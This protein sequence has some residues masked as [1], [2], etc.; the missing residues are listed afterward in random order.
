MEGLK[1]GDLIIT[2]KKVE[3]IRAIIG[4]LSEG[5]IGFITETSAYFDKLRVY[6]VSIGGKVYYLFEDEIKKLEEEC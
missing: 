6:G 3:N 4:Q 5:E 1:E 2:L